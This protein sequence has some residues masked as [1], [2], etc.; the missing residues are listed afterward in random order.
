MSGPTLLEQ[1]YRLQDRLRFVQS[2]QRERDTVPEEL[3]EVDRAYRER[4]ETLDGIRER[5][6]EA[7]SERRRAEGDL[8]DLQEKQ[9]KYQGQLRSV[10]SSREYG[11][12]LNEID[13]VDKLI[14]TTEDRVLAL[15]EEIE[16]ARKEL[17]AR[18]ESL[19]RE[20]EEHEEKLK[21][22]RTTQRG[23]DDELA[24]AATEIQEIERQMPPKDRAE[25]HRLIEKKGGVAIARV[26]AGSCSA[27]HV[28]IRPAAMQILKNGK[29]IVYCD[30]CKRILYWD[31]QP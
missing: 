10:Q 13:G 17:E 21:D 8:S 2:R 18:E 22:W 4:V 25:F 6:A 1:L 31:G 11:A 16:N 29:E 26:S 7:E 20:T 28:K 23:I 15:D 24:A 27:C 3:S 19:P 9:K 30:S 12:V 14:R 5:L